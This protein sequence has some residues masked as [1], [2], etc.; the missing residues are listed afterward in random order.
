MFE[1]NDP[2]VFFTQ[3]QEEH[4]ADAIATVKDAIRR[5]TDVVG[6]QMCVLRPEYRTERD[7]RSVIGAAGETP[8]YLTDYKRFD[9]WGTFS[10]EEKRDELLMGAACGAAL[11]DIP[12][13][14]FSGDDF[15]WTDDPAAAGKQ[16]EL[17]AQIHRG[18]GKVLI[19]T[20]IL[21]FT[22][23]NEVLELALAQQDRGADVVKIV[24][25]CDTN[26]EL[27]QTLAT[28]QALQDALEK[29]F[30]FLSSGEKG[31]YHRLIGPYFGA[32][33]WLCAPKYGKYDTAAQ[34]LL[35]TAI[36]SNAIF[37]NGNA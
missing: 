29:P 25:A 33:A 28:T 30:I 12:G 20:H 19:S 18:G 14:M 3:I 8:V 1:K 13:N 10:W 22:P 31:R 5:G 21:Q 17:I 2:P 36:R 35:E 9:K 34:P 15:E 7:I 6:F 23:Q 24:T 11:I 4:P 27:L 37:S 32:C 26:D 16:K